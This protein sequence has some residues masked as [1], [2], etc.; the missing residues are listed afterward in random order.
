VAVVLGLGLIGG[1]TAGAVINHGPRPEPPVAA[2]SPE[3]FAKVRTVWRN[4]PVDQLFPPT[5]TDHGGGPGGADR[6]WSRVGVAPPAGCA[7]A[8]DPL[9][10]RVLAP[11]GCARLLRATYVD[12][13]STTVTTVGLLITSGEAADMAALGRR[14]SA[15][16]LGGR[17]D[18]LPKPVAFPGTAA[19]RFGDRQRGSWTVQISDDLPIVVYAVSGFADGRT[20]PTPQAAQKAEAPDSTTATAQA[21]LGYDAIDLASAVDDRVQAAAQAQLNPSAH[22][23]PAQSPSGTPGPSRQA[24]PSASS[25]PSPAKKHS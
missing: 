9:L 23:A 14:W 15:E 20:V 25:N 1:A 12:T 6:A 5:L 2:G 3:A 13:T 4:T 10:Q 17:A 16:N 22:P 8:F 24:P 18:L 21:G 19:A 11:V 7:G